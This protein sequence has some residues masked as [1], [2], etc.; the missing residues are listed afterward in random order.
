[1]QLHQ[2]YQERL[3]Q[4]GFCTDPAQQPI[5]AALQQVA[6]ALTVPPVAGWRRWLGQATAPIPGLYIWGAVGRGKTWLMDLFFEHLPEPRKQRLHFH[7]FMQQVHQGLAQLKHKKEPLDRLA[8][9]MAVDWRI[10]CLDEFHVIDIGDA[11]IFAGL[12]RGLF[13]RGV[14]L[15]TTSNVP[16]A[17]LYQNG[18]QRDRFLPAIALLE[19][20]TRVLATHGEQDHRQSVAAAGQAYQYP[21]NATTTQ[22]LQQMFRQLSDVAHDAA[23]QIRI[24]GRQIAY[25][26]RAPQVI[27]FEFQ[28]LCGPPRSQHDYIALADRYTVVFISDIPAMTADDDDDPMRRF[29]ALIDELYD[30]RKQVVIS[31]AVPARQLYQGE[32]LTFEFQRTLSRLHEMQHDLAIG[33]F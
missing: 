32:R 22:R 21:L 27:W 17:E 19:Q 14:I 5:L 7:H 4:H 6:D 2:R 18:I 29:I 1:M 13:Q 9:Q 28:V 26:Q 25:R 11:M 10:L 23:G 31:A 24:Q 3:Q 12:L 20:H 33:H 30:R 16:P 15:I 8:A